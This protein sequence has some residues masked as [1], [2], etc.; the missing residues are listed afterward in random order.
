MNVRLASVLSLVCACATVTCRAFDRDLYN[1]TIATT[2][3]GAATTDAPVPDVILDAGPPTRVRDFGVAY[4]R[5]C[6]VLESGVVRCVG[7][8]MDGGLGD[9]T[10]IDSFAPVTVLGIT[11]A[12]RVLVGGGH[13]CAVVA[14]GNVWCWGNGDNGQI[15]NGLITA[16]QTTPV[17]IS[18]LR[19][20]QTFWIGILNSCARGTNNA[21]LCWGLDDR[22][23]LGDRMNMNITRPTSV[24]A[25]TGV[26]ELAL[27]KLH[28]CGRWPDSSVRC[29]AQNDYGQ[30]GDGTAMALPMIRWDPVV[31]PGMTGATQLALGYYHTCAI[32]PDRTVRCWGLNNH[33]QL[34]DGSLINRPSP[35]AVTG[36]SDVAQIVAGAFYTCARTTMGAVYCWGDGSGFQLGNGDTNDRP[37]ATLVPGLTGTVRIVSGEHNVCVG[38]MDQTVRCWGSNEHGQLGSRSASVGALPISVSW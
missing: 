26:Q 25:F 23:Q 12:Q 13:V 19:G 14:D 15:G 35:T 32:M 2:S 5:R 20:V 16:A 22:G 24:A 8:N 29:L 11:E 34:G 38:M 4:H 17:L 10:T 9:G 21:T 3:D 33:G 28:T 7:Y 27:N 30:L 1:D 31:V 36:L 6:A 37:R 18:G